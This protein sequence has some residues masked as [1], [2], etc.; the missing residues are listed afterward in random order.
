MHTDSVPSHQVVRR[1]FQMWN[2]GDLSIAP[3]V[4]SP[5]WTD[6]AHPEVN[7]PA[8]VQR[9]VTQ[10]HTTRPGLRFYIDTILGDD[11]LLSVVGGVGHESRPRAI[12]IRLI[13][14]IRVLDGQMVEMWTY[15]LSTP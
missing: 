15:R 2:T 13:W 6:H 7:G 12:D 11:D 10:T 14:L 8:D 1:Y 3:Q 5:D 9:A 4:L